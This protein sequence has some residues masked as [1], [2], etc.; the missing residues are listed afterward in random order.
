MALASSLAL[1][2]ILFAYSHYP[3]MKVDTLWIIAQQLKK[4]I[5]IQQV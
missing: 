2:I 4:L 3:M 1:T 5:P